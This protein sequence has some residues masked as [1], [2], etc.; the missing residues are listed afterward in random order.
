MTD[1]T[2]LQALIDLLKLLNTGGYTTDQKLAEMGKAAA[3]VE[4]YTKGKRPRDGNWKQIRK[5]A[6]ATIPP[7]CAQRALI[8]LRAEFGWMAWNL[9]RAGN[10]DGSLLMQTARHRVTEFLLGHGEEGEEE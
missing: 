9:G 3:V 8:L 4:A 1:N 5:L 6:I 2:P 7:D 10:E